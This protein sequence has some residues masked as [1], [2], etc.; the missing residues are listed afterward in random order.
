M[1]NYQYVNRRL[2]HEIYNI[3]PL[4]HLRIPL[5]G[6]IVD[7]RLGKVDIVHLVVDFKH[8]ELSMVLGSVRS[9]TVVATGSLDHPV[10]LPLITDYLT[11]SCSS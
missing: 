6:S 8:L 2:L 5:V 3:A 4:E 10:E 1:D 11:R 7:L 9:L